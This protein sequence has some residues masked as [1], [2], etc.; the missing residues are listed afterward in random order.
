M[1]ATSTEASS[2]G[3]TAR[4]MNR[5]KLPAAW[6]SSCSSGDTRAHA[7]QAHGHMHVSGEGV[8]AA[9]MW[10]QRPPHSWRGHARTP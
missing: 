1:P 10:G 5:R 9:G 7:T 4:S 3:V 8:A 2:P 6:G